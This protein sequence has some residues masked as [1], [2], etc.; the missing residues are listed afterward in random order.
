MILVC[1][2][3]Q[4]GLLTNP[5][6]SIA[7]IG[8]GCGRIAMFVAPALSNSGSYHG[9][10]TWS[11]GISWATDNITS[12]YPNCVFK[13][14]SDTQKETGYPANSFHRIDLDDNSCDLVLATS[15]FTHLRYSAMIYYKK[16]N[17]RIMKNSKHAYLI[18]FIYDEESRHG[19]LFIQ[20]NALLDRNLES[21][22]YGFYHHRWWLCRCRILRKKQS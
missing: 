7:D 20:E 9:F 10:D 8:C 18:F 12:H 2:L 5:N 15:L 6:A 1:D 21:D 4:F 17:H 11:A 22:E 19:A 13:T 16:E 14:L 3:I